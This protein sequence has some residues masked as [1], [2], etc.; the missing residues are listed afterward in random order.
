VFQ[1]EVSNGFG[2]DFVGFSFSEG[3]RFAEVVDEDGINEVNGEVVGD[4]EREEVD[5]VVAGGFDAD[6]DVVGVGEL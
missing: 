1:D 3:G 4:E 2:V 6:G 5:M